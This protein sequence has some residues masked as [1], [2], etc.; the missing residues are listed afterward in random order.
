MSPFYY[1]T[2]DG[3]LVFVYV[4]CN[5]LTVIASLKSTGALVIIITILVT[6]P[7]Y[8]WSLMENFWRLLQQA[9][10]RLDAFAIIQST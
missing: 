1:C 2:A 6:T 8:A 5:S 3:W 10:C 9:T 7:G 4:V